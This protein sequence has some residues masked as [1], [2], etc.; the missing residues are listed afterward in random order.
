MSRL[1][2]ALTSDDLSHHEADCDADVLQSTGLTAI[3][4]NLGVLLVEAKE[5]CAG[6]SSDSVSR[7]RDLQKALGPQVK[8]LARRWRVL[9][10]VDGVSAQ[11]VKELILD[12]CGVCQGRGVIPMKYDGTRLVDISQEE[13]KTKDVECVMCFGSGAARRDHNARVKA[14]GIK[15]Y[16]KQFGEWWEAVLQSCCDAEMSARR[17]IWRRLKESDI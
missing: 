5:G 16:T 7:I 4:Q 6:E 15:E 3:Q 12:R 11:V 9:V 2:A 1:S 10:S 13:S 14:A 8:R 17:A